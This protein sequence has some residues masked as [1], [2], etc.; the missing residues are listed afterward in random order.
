M[1][2]I[3]LMTE[4]NGGGYHNVFSG[5]QPTLPERY[6]AKSKGLS[7]R[8]ESIPVELFSGQHYTGDKLTIIRQGGCDDLSTCMPNV[9]NWSNRIRSIRFP[10]ATEIAT[11]EGGVELSPLIYEGEV[12]TLR[13]HMPDGIQYDSYSPSSDVSDFDG[14]VCELINPDRSD[15]ETISDCAGQDTRCIASLSSY[16][17][18][19]NVENAV[20]SKDGY[21][22]A[23]KCRNDVIEATFYS[24]YVLIC[25]P[26]ILCKA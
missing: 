13:L 20:S 11:R 17:Y 6:D 21:N 5:N 16:P 15:L 1:A 22:R 26:Y 4:I 7:V 9:G 18:Q 10:N 19:M 23:I 12:G 14:M 25:A 24:D 2:S 8:P 3:L